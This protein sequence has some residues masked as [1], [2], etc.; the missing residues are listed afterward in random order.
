MR[1]IKL[2]T[3]KRKASVTRLKVRKAIKMNN[4]KTEQDSNLHYRH[5]LLACFITAISSN[6][7]FGDLATNYV[8]CLATFSGYH[9][10]HLSIANI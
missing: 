7:A 2:K 6:D 1:K 5:P 3:L 10:R 9:F 8:V 4:K